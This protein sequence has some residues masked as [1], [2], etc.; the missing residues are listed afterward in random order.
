MVNTAC[1]PQYF[2]LI[3]KKVIL[4]ENISA[5]LVSWSGIYPLQAG[6]L[7]FCGFPN[8]KQL[9]FRWINSQLFS[10]KYDFIQT[11]QISVCLPI[12]FHEFGRWTCSCCN[13]WLSTR[14]FFFLIASRRYVAKLTSI[15][16]I[17]VFY[18]NR[19]HMNLLIFNIN[20]KFLRKFLHGRTKLYLTLRGIVRFS[21]QYILLISGINIIFDYSDCVWILIR[22]ISPMSALQSISTTYE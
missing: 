10:P 16:G 13:T 6:R 19:F 5:C 4:V 20:Q 8:I 2:T 21:S 1:R 3:S 14:F 11:V 12:R 17:S 9:K 22:R 15:V 7:F 18:S